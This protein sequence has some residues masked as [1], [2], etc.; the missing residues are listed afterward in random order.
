MNIF[1]VL[2]FVT[3]A[4][5]S[6]FHEAAEKLYV[7]QSSFSNNIQTI[8]RQLG[9]SLV[10]RGARGFSLT[11]AGAAFLV[12]AENIIGEHD[13][14]TTLLAEYKKAGGK[15]VLLFADHLSSFGYNDALIDFRHEAPEIQTELTELAG[16]S[17][18]DILKTHKNAV[19]IVF[20]SDE[21]TQPGTK[22]HT[23]LRDHLAVL[24]NKTHPLASSAKI[25]M[26]DLRDEPLQIVMLKQSPFLHDFVLQQ[27]HKAGF[28]PHI[29]SYTLW[30]STMIGILRELNHVAVIPKKVAQIFCP[31]DMRV[32]DITDADPYFINVVISEDCAHHAAVR[33]FDF[34]KK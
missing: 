32:I 19:C 6:T 15:R 29:N 7:S 33:F 8:E 3:L 2:C 11:E 22:K 18:A 34:A 23:L 26:Q 27:C 28:T 25:R 30:Y 21:A 17:I 16:E 5:A 14:M 13:R 9:V 4:H 1:Q 24:V 20:S 31:P 12:Y 10:E